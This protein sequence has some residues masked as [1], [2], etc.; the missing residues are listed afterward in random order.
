MPEFISWLAVGFGARIITFLSLRK[1]R[2][3]II[4]F[5]S[6]VAARHKSFSTC[7]TLGMMPRTY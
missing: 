5:I 2:I 4:T 3:I 7:K 1:R 6:Q